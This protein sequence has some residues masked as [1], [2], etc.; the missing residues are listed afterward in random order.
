ML[1]AWYV[2]VVLKFDSSSN[3]T[4]LLLQH[5]TVTDLLHILNKEEQVV[6]VNKFRNRI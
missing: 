3:K 5:V 6:I 1:L 4:M 2:T